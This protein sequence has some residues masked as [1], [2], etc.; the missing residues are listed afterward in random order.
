MATC[1]QAVASLIYS[2]HLSVHQRLFSS[3]QSSRGL[4]KWRAV[5]QRGAGSRL[6]SREFLGKALRR[7]HWHAIARPTLVLIAPL[8]HHPRA[9]SVGK[10]LAKRPG[11]TRTRRTL[12]KPVTSRPPPGK[13]RDQG[14]SE[15]DQRTACFMA[16]TPSPLNLIRSP[17]L[18]AL[19]VDLQ[20]KKLAPNLIWI[21]SAQEDPIAYNLLGLTANAYMLLIGKQAVAVDATSPFVTPIL[22]SILE[23]EQCSLS[24]LLLTH[25]HIAAAGKPQGRGLK[26]F[27]RAF[28]EVPVL[29]HPTD[30]EHEEAKLSGVDYRNPLKSEVLNSLGI[31]CW[32]FP[33]HTRGHVHYYSATYGG[34][35]FTGE[36][37]H[38]WA[39]ITLDVSWRSGSCLRHQMK[40]WSEL[41]LCCASRNP[42][43]VFLVSGMLSELLREFG[44]L[45]RLSI[46]SSHVR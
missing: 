44:Q 22:Q 4:V 46:S 7:E 17:S 9:M 14:S 32:E 16:P 8:T 1:C 20:P 11:T 28:P 37:C 43:F 42:V 29:L 30:A 36:T 40:H 34:A 38:S 27:R 13:G 26:C 33:G 6:V 18:S 10:G 45:R 5:L 23:R 31:K 19:S 24:A 15:T 2:C 41:W 12:Q 25:H 3:N 21:P 39:P 35:L